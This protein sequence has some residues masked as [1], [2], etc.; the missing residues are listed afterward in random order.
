MHKKPRAVPLRKKMAAVA[1]KDT[2]NKKRYLFPK[3]LT[4]QIK[5][6]GDKLRLSL[7]P[8]TLIFS[9]KILLDLVVASENIDNLVLYEFFDV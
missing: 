9:Y 2:Q 7:E 8:V 5:N 3:P 1:T 4:T 6:T